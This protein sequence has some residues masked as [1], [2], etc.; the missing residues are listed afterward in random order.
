MATREL[1]HLMEL[2]ITTT[3]RE[4]LVWAPTAQ[5]AEQLRRELTDAGFI[6]MD[7]DP[8]ELNA[9]GRIPEGEHSK[10]DPARIFN[11]EI[12]AEANASLQALIDSGHRLVWHRWQPRPP[13][14]VWGATV[15]VQRSSAGS[16][17]TSE[18]AVHFGIPVRATRGLNLRMTRETYARINKRSSFY[19]R[20]E[21]YPD[22]LWEQLDDNYDDPEHR[23]YTDAWCE[24]ERE[25][26][27]ANFDLNMAHFASLDPAEFE[28]ALQRAAK[29][30]GMAEITDLSKWDGVPGLY[31]MVLDE[32]RQ[33]YV[34]GAAGAG[35]IMKRVKQH[36]TR[37]QP[38]DRLI[39]PDV[40]SSILA[41]DS[42]RALDTT[43]IFAL[44]TASPFELEAELLESIPAKFRLNRIMGGRDAVKLA[45]IVGV[46]KVIKRRKFPAPDDQPS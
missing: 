25:R 36:W 1:T 21:D 41:I 42:F 9:F 46:D 35:G 20:R 39:W 6:V 11:V 4:T 43:R 34:G 7:A 24:E 16:A 13:R 30:Y 31:I 26:A 28:N 22:G 27:L 37:T 15:S 45:A 8:W 18:S 10:F 38:L 29:K 3:P 2:E 12:G 23:F 19:V 17:S 5:D 33:V 44:K 40:E 14:K 32:Y